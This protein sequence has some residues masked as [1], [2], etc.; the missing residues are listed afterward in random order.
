MLKHSTKF[1]GM[2]REYSNLYTKLVELFA[3]SER[4]KNML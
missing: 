1:G 3:S 2:S 4:P